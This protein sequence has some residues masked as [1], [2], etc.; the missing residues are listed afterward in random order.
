MTSSLV[1]AFISTALPPDV[2]RGYASP[3]GGIKRW[4]CASGMAF[5]LN[6]LG[7]SPNRGQSPRLHQS[8]RQGIASRTSGGKAVEGHLGPLHDE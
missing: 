4:G 2:R 3:S 1:S 6:D 8:S 7:L 5:G